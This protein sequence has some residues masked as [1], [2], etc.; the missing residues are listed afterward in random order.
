MVTFG[1]D[2]VTFKDGGRR[3]PPTYLGMGL[4]PPLHSTRRVLLVWLCGSEHE[5]STVCVPQAECYGRQL[6]WMIGLIELISCRISLHPFPGFPEVEARAYVPPT[7]LPT[8]QITAHHTC[9]TTM[10]LSIL[11]ATTSIYRMHRF[12]IR[13]HLHGTHAQCTQ[14][15]RISVS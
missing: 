11:R 7:I 12:F 8:I 14:Q 4:N 13:T 2:A 3:S 15:I 6:W 5:P 1:G 9:S 10:P